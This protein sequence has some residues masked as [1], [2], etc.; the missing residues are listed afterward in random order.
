MHRKALLVGLLFLV[1]GGLA[2]VALPAQKVMA[3]S[4]SGADIAFGRQ[5]NCGWF[6]NQYNDEGGPLFSNGMGTVED[7]SQL[8]SYI[9]AKCDAGGTSE[10]SAAVIIMDMLGYNAPT[11]GGCSNSSMLS[12]WGTDV[13]GYTDE[14][15]AND[16]CQGPSGSVHFNEGQ[17]YF[18]GEVDTYLSDT[19]GTYD[20][21]PF[22]IE[23]NTDPSCS[24]GQDNADSA[25][26]FYNNSGNQIFLIR[27]ACG[28]ILRAIGHLSAPPPPYNLVP[29]VKSKVSTGQ[30]IAVPGDTITFTFAVANTEAGSSDK[31]TC[32]EYDNEYDG[33]HGTP[34]G[35]TYDQSNGNPTSKLSACSNLVFGGNSNTTLKTETITVT[36]ADVNH[37][38]CR[39]LY[40][41]PEATGNT[42]SRGA[43]ACVN[44]QTYA[45]VPTVNDTSSGGDNAF[46]EVGDTVTFTYAVANTAAGPSHPATCKEYAYNPAGYHAA[47]NPPAY[48]TGGTQSTICT[49]EVFQGNQTVTLKTE[50]VTV[51]AAMAD[52]TLCRTLTVA[53]SSPTVA[54][55]GSEACV[56]IV[57]MPYARV[58][59]GDIS[60]GNAQA[61]ATCSTANDYDAGVVGWNTES[62]LYNG[63]GAQFAA[64]AIGEIAHFATSQTNVA[65]SK[66][67]APSGLSFANTTT[68]GGGVYGGSLGNGSLPCMN[69]YYVV[70]AG[71]TDI[72]NSTIDLGTLASGAY[73]YTGTSELTISGTLASG[74]NPSRVQLFVPNQNVYVANS[75]LYQNNWQSI[76]QIPMFELVVN[77]GNIL[78]SNSAHEV[79]GTYIAQN[80]AANGKGTGGQIA[81]CATPAGAVVPTA[82]GSLYTSCNSTLTVN[83]AFVANDVALER[84]A[85]TLNDSSTDN[86][87]NLTSSAAEQFNYN[88]SLW[89]IQPPTTPGALTYNTIV[90]LPPV[91]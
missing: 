4:C 3:A 28:N 89:L 56:P 79:D 39:T 78:I 26:V 80:S 71:A 14:G 53:P 29:S 45:L 30:T 59:G 16:I 66:G 55:L 88:P 49:A 9:D 19:G 25:I 68:G 64:F 60:A 77:S 40:V 52:T 50:V 84:S 44:V 42:G 18:C 1:V 33:N 70:P 81:T 69:N 85:N 32:T 7:G 48:D 87:A 17:T 27:R 90:D 75:I 58:F 86:P 63:A 13:L 83:G 65:T 73:V 62:G 43:E 24:A 23:A 47:P 76:S 54:V 38:F 57:N 10:T 91:L 34:G 37:T 67:V 74:T 12:T 41:A 8:V 15:C 72:T 51:T 35:P 46:A 61:S 21:A 6:H 2:Y 31:T 36:V 22:L 11:T 82:G 5:Q 20:V